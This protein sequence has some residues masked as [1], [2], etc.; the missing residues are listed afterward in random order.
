MPDTLLTR[1]FL[2]AEEVFLAAIDHI[3]EPGRHGPLGTLSAPGRVVAHVAENVD[4]Q[5]QWFCAGA[6]RDPWVEEWL[7][8][9]RATPDVEVAPPLDECRDAYMRIAAR[10][11]EWVT[12]ASEA[13]LRGPADTS[14]T[15]LPPTTRGYQVART[16]AHLFV[17]AGELSVIAA[18]VRAGDLGLPGGLPRSSQPPAPDDWTVPI[19]AALL[20]DAYAELGRAAWA[21]PQPAVAGASDRFNPVS[22]TLMHV[23]RREDIQWSNI[24]AGNQPHP[25]VMELEGHP[26]G[27]PIEDW[28]SCME[29]AA[30]IAHQA[31][32]WLNTVDAQTG[33]KPMPWG[34]RDSTVGAQLARSVGHVFSHASE[35]ATISSQY[36]GSDLGMPGAMEFLH[37][38]TSG[39][40]RDALA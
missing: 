18:M 40:A 5:I 21:A 22:Y 27:A 26:P 39:G 23:M 29:A 20:Q 35:I 4:R 28:T 2:D 15:S 24:A 30:E 7:A 17:H 16:A 6:P 9:H 37:Q 25:F 8:R 36:G 33:A 3:P 14:G 11:A 12:G 38:A 34:A 31:S 19:V 13:T 32:T 10:A 1:L